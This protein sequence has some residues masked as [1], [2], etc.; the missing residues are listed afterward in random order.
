M[1]NSPDYTI[2]SLS[3]SIEQRTFKNGATRAPFSLGG[4]GRIG[5]RGGCIPY[6]AF[7]SSPP[8]TVSDCNGFAP[9]PPAPALN[10]DAGYGAGINK[11]VYGPE[12]SVGGGGLPILVKAWYG[13]GINK[14]VY[15]PTIG[16]GELMVKAWYG[17]GINKQVYGPKITGGAITINAW[18]GKGIN[19]QVYGPEISG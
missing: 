17:K 16:G 19:K 5:L 6:I 13:K 12:V 14:Q 8:T 15:G 2:T 9:T 11:Q 10:I 4:T 3:S 18:Y 7:A 1:S